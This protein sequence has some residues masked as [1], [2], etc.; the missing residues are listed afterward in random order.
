MF[1]LSLGHTAGNCGNFFFEV[2][3]GIKRYR[4]HKSCNKRVYRA[5]QQARDDS[6]R[7]YMGVFP[8]ILE[9]TSHEILLRPETDN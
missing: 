4:N 1:T 6:I 9:M 7:P 3:F 5:F 8:V 2:K